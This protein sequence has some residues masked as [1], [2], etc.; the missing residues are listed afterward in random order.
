MS[1]RLWLLWLLWLLVTVPVGATDVPPPV[2]GSHAAQACDVCHGADGIADCDR[3]HTAA[4]NP[5]PVGIAAW[6]PVPDGF[7][8]DAEG[9][10]LCRTCHRLHGGEPST[11]YLRSASAAG[12]DLECVDSRRAFCAWCHDRGTAGFNPHLGRQGETRCW[13]CHTGVPVATEDGRRTLRAEVWRLCRFCHGVEVQKH[14][15]NVEV[16]ESL[17]AA[18]PLA[19]D[20]S[21]TCATCHDPHGTTTATH[22]LR[23]EFAPSYGRAKGESPHVDEYRACRAC[24]TTSFRDEIRPPGYGLLYRGDRNL[25]CLSCHV[26]DQRHHP[27]AVQLSA[28]FRTRWEASA[29]RVPLDNRDRVTCSTCHDPHLQSLILKQLRAQPVRL[30]ARCHQQR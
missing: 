23:P 7:A 10:L 6:M 19:P 5:H 9:R 8:L 1:W 25:L 17:P 3:C 4:A 14:W 12:G 13:V 30:C 18:L 16:V 28:P 26:T 11:Y 21:R 24:H 29:L 27:T 22:H 20:G 15:H 2:T